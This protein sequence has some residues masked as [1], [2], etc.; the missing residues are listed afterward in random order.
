MLVTSSLGNFLASPWWVRMDRGTWVNPHK[1]CLR[2]SI[3]E[4][5]PAQ[6]VIC[7]CKA[8]L[9]LKQGGT[10]QSDDRFVPL[11]ERAEWFFFC[12]NS[13]EEHSPILIK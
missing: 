11:I 12:P 1:D 3:K 2:L 9:A 4:V 5:G 6:T 13:V 7:K 10:A 8:R